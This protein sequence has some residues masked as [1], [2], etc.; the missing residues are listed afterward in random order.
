MSWR[1]RAVRIGV[2]CAVVLGIAAALKPIEEAAEPVA[3]A[4][5]EPIER[6]NHA[7]RES[8][9]EIIP[10]RI[11][12]AFFGRMFTSGSPVTIVAQ[13]PAAASVAYERVAEQPRYAQLLCLLALG[14]AVAICWSIWKGDDPLVIKIAWFTIATMGVA[15]AIGLLLW[16]LAWALSSL[17]LVGIVV[18]ARYGFNVVEHYV[19]E[20]LDHRV[21]RWLGVSEAEGAHA[22]DER[23]E[24]V[25]GGG[26]K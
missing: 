15:S 18:L 2:T 23:P 25:A 7:L 5:K 1:R 19:V 11:A 3:E 21:A 10:L 8:V 6:A 26:A 13:I 9:G 16:V 12:G 24:G 4:I 17:A 20:P 14:F 22:A